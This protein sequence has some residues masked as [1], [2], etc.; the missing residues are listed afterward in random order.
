MPRDFELAG[1]G[2]DEG[3]EERTE[4]RTEE[5]NPAG[6]TELGVDVP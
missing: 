5:G 3:T 1:I 6:L 4:E 2:R